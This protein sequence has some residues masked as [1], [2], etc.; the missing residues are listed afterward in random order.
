MP[1]PWY[2]SELP[3]WFKAEFGRKGDEQVA[4]R[5]RAQARILRNLNYPVEEAIQ[6]VRVYLSW[7]WELP[8]KQQ[9]PC[10]DQVDE[11]VREAYKMGVKHIE[12]GFPEP[13]KVRKEIRRAYTER[14]LEPGDG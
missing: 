8:R 13:E 4:D 2:H 10:W 9:V 11:L 6:R 12:R 1:F 7:E 5:V 3:D 14:N